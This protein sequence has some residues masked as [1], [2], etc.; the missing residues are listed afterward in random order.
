MISAEHIVST[1]EDFVRTVQSALERTGDEEAVRRVGEL[2]KRLQPGAA[3]VTV[4]F[5]GL[6]CAGKSSLINAL[7]GTGELAA[8]A[9]PT[10]AQVM[11]LPLPGTAGR[12]LLLDTPGIDSTQAGYQV[13]TEVAMHGADVVVLVVDYQHVETHDNLILARSLAARCKR[14]LLVVHQV[15]KH[16]AWE[17]PFTELQA[18]VKRTLENWGIDVAA[19]FY[20][21]TQPTVHGQ[22]EELRTYLGTLAQSSNGSVD[23]RVLAALEALV[24]QHVDRELASA[25]QA[26]VTRLQ[27]TLG[28]VPYD[29]VEAAE[30]LERV[31]SER[32]SL[33]AELAAERSAQCAREEAE[34]VNLE[35][36][37]DL[38][39]IAPYGTTE[40]GRAYIESLQP[41]FKPGWFRAKQRV[42]Q[43]RVMRCEQFVEELAERTRTFLAWPLQG[44]MR[45][46]VRAA[47]G[48]DDVWLAEVDEV[49]V[50][51]SELE[52]TSQVKAGAL[53]LA[54]YPYQYVKDVVAGVKC[55][56]RALLM[57]WLERWFAASNQE[58]AQAQSERIT[59]LEQLGRQVDALN[60]WTALQ[61][62]R[63]R[64][65]SELLEVH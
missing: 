52:C 48:A 44:Q 46:M 47:H 42:E 19:V 35:H 23:D 17:L 41:G 60:A 4:A 64:K 39:Q 26:C 11:Q 49:M 24:D 34:R 22:L 8:G 12:V 21:A 7:T 13:V 63:D 31:K 65:I 3:Q 10:T 27:E 57:D 37:I 15:D 28:V 16:L 56:F 33:K 14:L 43:E 59:Q 25:R 36:S 61:Q 40:L 9:V 53:A 30:L 55:R 18:G 29:D 58:L 45:S 54:E 32:D 50:E 5:C 6:V 51:V 2:T 62:E 20:T 1:T 38:A